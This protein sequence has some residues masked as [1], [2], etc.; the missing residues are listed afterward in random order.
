MEALRQCNFSRS[1]RFLR[2]PVFSWLGGDAN[3][4]AAMLA[5]AGSTLAVDPVSCPAA[6]ARGSANAVIQ[7]ATSRTYEAGPFQDR[8]VMTSPIKA[9]RELAVPCIYALLTRGR[10][11]AGISSRQRQCVIAL[12]S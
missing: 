5:A 10:S 2:V 12:L 7:P 1:R 3:A 8:G 6:A 4:P 11:I 9:T